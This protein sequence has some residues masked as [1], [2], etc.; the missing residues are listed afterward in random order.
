MPK[1]LPGAMIAADNIRYHDMLYIGGTLPHKHRTA[2]S[3][4]REFLT[5]IE[6]ETRFESVFLENG[7]GMTVSRWKG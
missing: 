6:D 5:M 4:L 2:V 3:R 1:L 7:D